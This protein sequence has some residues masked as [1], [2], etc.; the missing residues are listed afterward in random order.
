MLNRKSNVV[1]ITKGLNPEEKICSYYEDIDWFSNGMV[2]CN[3]TKFNYD[4]LNIRFK[5][6]SEVILT[7]LSNFI[8]YLK[9]KNIAL[10]KLDIEGGEGKAI[11]SGIE[12][13]TRF[14]VP[15][16]FVEFSPVFLNEHG[17]NPKK[18]LKFFIENGYKISIKG[19]LNNIFISEKKLIKIVKDRQM[20][21]YFIHKDIID[22]Y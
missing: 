6:I 3:K 16:I 12:I 17:T 8:P 7:K 19:F 22:I 14:H 15:F 9:D 4:K 2:V 10:I 20:N 21:I 13:I 18:F 11:E 1:I 5:K